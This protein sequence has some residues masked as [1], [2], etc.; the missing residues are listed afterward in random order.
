MIRLRLESE[1]RAGEPSE[2]QGLVVRWRVRIVRDHDDETLEE[3]VGEVHASLV[4][5]GTATNVGADLGEALEAADESLASVNAAFF[6]DE[7]WLRDDFDAQGEGL[8]YV[9]AIEMDDAN[10]DRLIDLAAVSR[11]ADTLGLGCS[12]LVLGSEE[13]RWQP[14]WSR[15]G[16]EVIAGPNDEPFLVL[17]LSKR[18]PRVRE[19]ADLDRF[20]VVA[21]PLPEGVGDRADERPREGRN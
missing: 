19:A 2:D 8:L 18:T 5:Y 6:D 1:V 16:F 9:N 17:N 20:E 11:L 4:H 12:L 10:R 14:K 21:A 13:M 15:L 7:G 3:A